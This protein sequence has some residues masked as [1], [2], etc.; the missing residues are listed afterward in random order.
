VHNG[1]C[2]VEANKGPSGP[3]SKHFVPNYPHQRGHSNF[4]WISSMNVA[5]HEK[6]MTGTSGNTNTHH[7]G[8][9]SCEFNF[10]HTPFSLIDKLDIC[11]KNE[12]P[13]IFVTS[14]G[15]MFH[16]FRHYFPNTPP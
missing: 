7:K 13:N 15:N 10:P 1:G 14:M 3:S 12:K 16:L 8:R 2:D 5:I 11:F 4:T 9:N 6:K